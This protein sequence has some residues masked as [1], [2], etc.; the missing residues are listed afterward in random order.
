MWRRKITEIGM[1][2]LLFCSL[3][4]CGERKEA[5][6]LIGTAAEAAV[7]G[8]EQTESAGGEA[9]ENSAGA[10]VAGEGLGESRTGSAGGEAGESL[11]G[12]SVAGEG[13]GESRTGSAG[14]EAGESSAGIAGTGENLTESSA[15][16]AVYVCGAVE[17]PGI[18]YLPEGSRKAEALEA[19][20][21]FSE[22]AD[23]NYVNL[24][25]KIKDG[26]QIYFPTLAEGLVSE[27]LVSEAEKT[28]PGAAGGKEE[29]AAVNL[30]TADVA[31]L[32]T[33][34]GIGEARAR[35]IIRY[36]EQNGRFERR[37]DIMKVSG[38]KEST[39]EKIKEQISVD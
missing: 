24:A 33:L 4:G 27:R 21:G 12:A 35:D 20:G 26:E 9:G 5:E 29:G 13:L 28:V 31:A 32:C 10:S 34:T 8:E 16:V 37:E 23:R 1:L 6:Q 2:L 22:D 17:R 30:N 7:L 15:Q 3:C 18:V 38:I 14:G 39:Y 36:R 19:A 11:A 25:A